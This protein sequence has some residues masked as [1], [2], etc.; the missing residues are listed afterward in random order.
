MRLTNN[1]K[2]VLKTLIKG[3][4]IQEIRKSKRV[5]MIQEKSTEVYTVDRRS[6]YKLIKLG[7][8]ECAKLN[9]EVVNYKIKEGVYV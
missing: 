6:Y 5:R 8:I 4:Y 2:E 3:F 1:E 9:K 7:L